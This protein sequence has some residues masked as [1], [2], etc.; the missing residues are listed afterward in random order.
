[1]SREG[2]SG[3]MGSVTALLLRVSMAAGLDACWGVCRRFLLAVV[4]RKSVFFYTIWHIYEVKV[5]KNLSR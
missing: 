1:M 2:G 5:A 3:P 4:D